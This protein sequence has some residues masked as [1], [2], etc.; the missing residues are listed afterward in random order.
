MSHIVVLSAP[1]IGTS[2]AKTFFAGLSASTTTQCR[3]KRN[4]HACHEEFPAVSAPKMG[5]GPTKRHRDVSQ[6]AISMA[7][8]ALK[9]VLLVIAGRK[10]TFRLFVVG[11]T[12]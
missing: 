7:R 9:M 10:Q 5:A 6:I 2:L 11:P 8:F 12:H 3:T 4:K 1:N